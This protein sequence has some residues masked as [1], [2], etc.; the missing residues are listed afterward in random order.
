MAKIK[1]SID[2]K[3]YIESAGLNFVGAVQ[4][5]EESNIRA[6]KACLL[7]GD[8]FVDE[9]RLYSLNVLNVL[10][11]NEWW[12][13]AVFN[14]RTFPIIKIAA[15]WMT[16]SE[17][18][19]LLD[20]WSEDDSFEYYN[21]TYSCSG[22]EF[23]EKR[24]QEVDDLLDGKPVSGELA[25]AIAAREDLDKKIQSEREAFI[26]LESSLQ[27]CEPGVA[28]YSA[29]TPL[30]HHKRQLQKILSI[31][32]KDP[33]FWSNLRDAYLMGEFSGLLGRPDS[34]SEIAKTGLGFKFQQE[35]GPETVI[36]EKW[37]AHAAV[38][39]KNNP[40]I[41][42]KEVLRELDVAGL[43]E[44][45]KK[46]EGYDKDGF[47][48]AGGGKTP[49]AVEVGFKRAMSRLRKKCLIKGTSP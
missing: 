29:T 37:K 31:S 48:L 30:Q 40:S 21:S 26:E 17:Q 28:L 8:A 41:S 44:F 42:D 2:K 6:V 20:K 24:I 15:D 5:V 27:G 4:D 3:A 47:L 13:P 25:R 22:R 39:I 49:L 19:R 35:K 16:H 1:D 46:S 10:A 43:V 32:N 38:L 11:K 33:E 14:G 45:V 23:F 18:K 36:K 7:G 12:V 34:I 9:S